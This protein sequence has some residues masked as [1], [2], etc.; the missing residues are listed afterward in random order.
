MAA[1]VPCSRYL[2]VA[3]AIADPQTVERGTMAEVE[4]AAGPL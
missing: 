4:D 3:E 1:G 2:T